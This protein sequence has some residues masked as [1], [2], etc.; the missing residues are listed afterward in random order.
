MVLVLQLE[1]FQSAQQSQHHIHS[2]TDRSD[3]STYSEYCGVCKLI[4]SVILYYITGRQFLSLLFISGSLILSLKYSLFLSLNYLPVI[5]LELFGLPALTWLGSCN[6]CN[7][8][9]IL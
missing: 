3:T 1:V 8:A 4:T 9:C 5:C 6:H 7:L 2:I